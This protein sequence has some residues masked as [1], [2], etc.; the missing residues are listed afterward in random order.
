MRYLL[1]TA[2]LSDFVRGNAAVMAQIRQRAP[3]DL[4][5]SVITEHEVEYGLQRAPHLPA[6]V[7]EAMRDLMGAVTVLALEREDA[8]MAASIRAQ[9][10]AQG[11]PLGAYD[12]LL[13]A[14]AL[15]HNLIMVSHNTSEFSRLSGLRLED[16][17]G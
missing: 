13:A 1:D 8:R 15:R 4:A 5:V 16:W 17:R 3:S 11:T 9:L 12:L 7:V 6:P 10:A 14:T 2:V